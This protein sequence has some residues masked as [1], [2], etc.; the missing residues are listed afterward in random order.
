M[1][2]IPVIICASIGTVV[3]GAFVGCVAARLGIGL[4]AIIQA[5][6]VEIKEAEAKTKQAEIEPKT[7]EDKVF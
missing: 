5:K 4:V 6:L 7:A 1:T 3:A 2:R